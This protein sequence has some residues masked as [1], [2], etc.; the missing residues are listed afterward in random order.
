MIRL[1]PVLDLSISTS[2][3]QVSVYSKCMKVTVD[4]IQEPRS[5]TGKF[6]FP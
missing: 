5:K 3:P 6:I 1:E 2:P 4:G